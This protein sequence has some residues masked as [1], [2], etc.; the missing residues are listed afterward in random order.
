MVN[1]VNLRQHYINP[2][3]VIQRNNKAAISGLRLQ[4][5]A[6]EFWHQMPIYAG[7]PEPKFVAG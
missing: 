5:K 3:Q 2:Q 6:R 7:L 4:E 1:T